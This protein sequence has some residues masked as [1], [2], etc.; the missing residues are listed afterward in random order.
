MVTI[1]IGVM[2][3]TVVTCVALSTIAYHRKILDK[4]GCILAF[5]MGMV[6]G[7]AGS[8]VW[9]VLLLVFLF[10]SFAATRYRYEMKRKK[11]VAEPK[12]GKRGFENVLAN[13]YVPMVIAL[14][15]YDY[16]DPIPSIDKTVATVMFITAIASAASDTLASELGVFANRTYMITNGKR[17]RAGVNGGVSALGTGAALFA[18]FYATLLG[19]TLIFI[20]TP[21]ILPQNT[22]YVLIPLLL[23][24][25]GCHIDSILGAVFENRGLLTGSR[26][27][28]LSIFNSA[29]IAYI[30]MYA[31][32]N[33]GIPWT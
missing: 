24:F 30:L 23:G 1:E 8:I 14:L 17:V 5:I 18:A 6:I 32:P 25:L 20:W 2:L 31:L 10:S 13:G 33:I 27:N 12:G 21:Y 4:G 19:W 7:L 15:S 9:L 22:W 28:L 3:L 11:K 16:P 29:F 26:V